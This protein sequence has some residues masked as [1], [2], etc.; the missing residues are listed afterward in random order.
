MAKLPPPS[1]DQTYVSVS[2]LHGGQLTLPERLFI[3]DADPDKKSLV[4]SMCFLITHQTTTSSTPTRLV[5]D[6]G[7]K[8]DL[9]KYSSGMQAHIA[10]RQPIHTSLDVHSSLI[11][12]GLD[13]AKDINMVILSH[14]HWDHIG[15]PSD[16]PSANFLVGSGTL[17][18]VTHGASHYPASMF[19]VEPLPLD[20][21][22]EFPCADGAPNPEFACLKD[23]QVQ[24]EWKAV[25]TLPHCIDLFE[26]GS[27]FV[28]DAPGHLQGHANLLCRISEKKWVYLG[29]DCC[30]DAR[31]LTGEKGVAEY[32]DGEGGKRSVH[33]NLPVAK[34]TIGMIQE[35][36]KVNTGEV[37]VE[38]VIA[39]DRGWMEKN[40]DKFLPGKMS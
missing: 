40:G 36:I 7:L 29:G 30:H 6:L 38:W 35:F 32:D 28:V 26:D 15:L 10:N 19:E 18:T 4:P 24:K 1:D 13:P 21:T 12:G 17:H 3:T 31:I 33:S 5:F 37:E 22:L 23:R 39:H 34:K 16:Y 14:T 27:V 11:S 9:S 25:S 8:R 20:R 2:A